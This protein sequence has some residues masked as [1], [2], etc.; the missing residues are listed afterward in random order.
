M[1]A[2][3]ASVLQGCAAEK[4][5]MSSVR[6]GAKNKK[7]L[8][9]AG[10]EE[11]RWVCGGDTVPVRPWTASS[12][13]QKPPAPLGRRKCVGAPH[14]AQAILPSKGQKLLPW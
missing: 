9:K 7:Q 4:A 12:S 13:R 6:V 3:G 10:L 2:C 11:R 5:L 8:E 14:Q 1:R